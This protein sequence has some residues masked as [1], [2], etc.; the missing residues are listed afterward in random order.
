MAFA[1]KREQVSKA[2]RSDPKDG[3]G[4]KAVFKGGVQKFKYQEVLAKKKLIEEAE[5]R[6]KEQEK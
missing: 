3:G 2:D 6:L 4:L 1:Q 5:E